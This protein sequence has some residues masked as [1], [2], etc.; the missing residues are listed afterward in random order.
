MSPVYTGHAPQLA[1]VG[2]AC[3][4]AF[5]WLGIYTSIAG[6]SFESRAPVALTQKANHMIFIWKNVPS[7]HAVAIR[8]RRCR[9]MLQDWWRSHTCFLFLCFGFV[10]SL[11]VFP[12]S[13][14]AWAWTAKHHKTGHIPEAPTWIAKHYKNT[15]IA[16][17]GTIETSPRK[18]TKKHTFVVVFSWR[19]RI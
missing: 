13:P 15:H 5:T 16:Q 7:P 3:H 6:K 2:M 4:T 1:F 18:K 10:L 9:G 12:A 11:F 17:R 8:C 19:T 14:N